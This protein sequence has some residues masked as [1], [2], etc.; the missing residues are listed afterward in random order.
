MVK[1]HRVKQINFLK[2]EM[3]SNKNQ[4][5]NVS[6]SF[7]NNEQNY[8]GDRYNGLLEMIEIESSEDFSLNPKK[9]NSNFAPKETNLLQNRILGKI[10]SFS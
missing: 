1:K 8:E 4:S 9:P 2:I 5:Y 7:E 10:V 3:T 6:D